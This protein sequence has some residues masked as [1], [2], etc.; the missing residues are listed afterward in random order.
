MDSNLNKIPFSIVTAIKD[1]FDFFRITI[2]SVLQQTHNRWEWII[3]DDSSREP[4]ALAIPE[5]TR[6]PRIK[7]IRH[8]SPKGQTQGLNEA[9]CQSK[10]DWIVRMDGDDI[11]ALDRLQKTAQTIASMPHVQMVFSD[12]AVIDEAGTTLARVRY[13]RPLSAGFFSYL[14]KQ[15]NP[16]CHPSVSFKKISASGKRR[17]YREDL[18]NAQDYALW[19]EILKDAGPTALA[20]I[21]SQTL[22]YRVVSNSLSGARAPEQILELKAIRSGQT[23]TTTNTTS[24]QE[25]EKQGMQCYRLLYYRFIGDAPAIPRKQDFNLLR[26]ALAY[27]KQLLPALILFTFRPAKRLLKYFLF[28]GIYE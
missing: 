27:P 13:R 23:I 14:E 16:I 10:Y 12:Y 15:N 3:V 8:D 25:K 7:I 21:P 19:K 18:K 5:L 1:G 22:A 4:L 2:P 20:A 6:D 26:G 11:C 28:Q 24:L 17:L 9:I